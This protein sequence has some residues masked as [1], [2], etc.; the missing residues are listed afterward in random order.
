M[1]LV[2]SST[3]HIKGPRCF[4]AFVR[5]PFHPTQTRNYVTLRD[6]VDDGLWSSVPGTRWCYLQEANVWHSSPR[7]RQRYLCGGNQHESNKY[8]SN[9]IKIKFNFA[10]KQIWLNVAGRK[11]ET[12]LKGVKATCLKMVRYLFNMFAFSKGKNIFFGQILQSYAYPI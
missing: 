11:R 10:G 9:K 3:F 4:L 12:Y 7:T 2:W 6:D 1:V 5:P 8:F